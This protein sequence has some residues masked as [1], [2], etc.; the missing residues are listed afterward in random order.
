LTYG[1][2]LIF[3]IKNEKIN[4][5]QPLECLKTR[6]KQTE[7]LLFVT[8]SEIIFTNEQQELFAIKI[9]QTTKLNN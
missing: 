7:A 1:K 6:R 2:I 8:N 5:K 3:G 9:G 4:F